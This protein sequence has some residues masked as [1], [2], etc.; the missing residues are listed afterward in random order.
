MS[1]FPTLKKPLAPTPGDNWTSC[2]VKDWTY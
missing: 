1:S 2:V